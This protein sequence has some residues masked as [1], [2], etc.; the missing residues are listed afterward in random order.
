MTG[1]DKICI[2]KKWKNP[3]A[4][5]QTAGRQATILAGNAEENS[6]AK[7]GNL[8]AV[9]PKTKSTSVCLAAMFGGWKGLTRDWRR[10]NDNA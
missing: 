4:T 6:D 7:H 3:K 9:G 10:Q 5:S 8:A 2:L 1:E